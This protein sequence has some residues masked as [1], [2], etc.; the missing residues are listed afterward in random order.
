MGASILVITLVFIA[1]G[2]CSFAVIALLR[3]FRR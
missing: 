3:A 1:G 2:L